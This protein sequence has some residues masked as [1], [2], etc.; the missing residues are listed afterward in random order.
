MKR[1]CSL[2]G[3]WLEKSQFSGMKKDC[4]RCRV[5]EDSRPKRGQAK[6]ERALTPKGAKKNA[7]EKARKLNESTGVPHELDHVIPF[8]SKIR[9]GSD[10]WVLICGLDIPENWQIIPKEANRKKWMRFS[11]E[12]AKAEEKRMMLKW[13]ERN[14]KKT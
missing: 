13:R 1:Q 7:E 9:R 5:I 8:R 3:D 2:C 11:K 6:I 4:M 14:A 10:N 12:D